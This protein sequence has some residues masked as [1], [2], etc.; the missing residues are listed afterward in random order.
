MQ[1]WKINLS[2]HIFTFILLMNSRLYIRDIKCLG[3][4]LHLQPNFDDSIKKIKFNWK[5]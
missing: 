2:E 5:E 3:E 1:I 4:K